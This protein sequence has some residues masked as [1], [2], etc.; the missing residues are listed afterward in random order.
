MWGRIQHRR[1]FMAGALGIRLRP[2][3]LPFSNMPAYLTPF[4]LSPED[5]M[6]VQH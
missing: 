3:V 1:E 4:F 2:E 6:V 5:A